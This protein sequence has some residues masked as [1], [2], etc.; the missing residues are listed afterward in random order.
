MRLVIYLIFVYFLTFNPFHFSLHYLH[1]FFQFRKRY[2]AAIISGSSITDIIPNLIM[3]F[4]FGWLGRG[5][6]K[7][8]V[9]KSIVSGLIVIVPFL[10]SSLITT[11]YFHQTLDLHLFYICCF[12]SLLL[13]VIS[14]FYGFLIA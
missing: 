9:R 1:Q 5:L 14:L 7:S 4:P 2:L 6:V 13:L 11:I 3:L 12:I 10:I 8:K